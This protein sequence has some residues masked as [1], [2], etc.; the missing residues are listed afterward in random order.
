MSVEKKLCKK[1]YTKKMR[2]IYNGCK[3]RKWSN[4]MKENRETLLLDVSVS[5]R[6][7]IRKVQAEI[8]EL[9][10]EYMPWNEFVILRA[11]MHSS[12]QTASQIASEVD[13]T[14]SHVTAVSDRLVEKEYISRTRSDLDRRIVNLEITEQGRIVA[15]KLEVLRKQYYKEKFAPWNDEEIKLVAMLL[16]RIL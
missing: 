16:H 2:M 6:H 3:R 12:P 13:V 7:M 8:N 4:K 14:S 9:F 10:S 5:L 15:N 1:M 11:L